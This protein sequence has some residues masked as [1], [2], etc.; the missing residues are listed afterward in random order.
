[1]KIGITMLAV[2]ASHTAAAILGA[3]DISSRQNTET[4]LLAITDFKLNGTGCPEKSS[5]SV[6]YLDQ[7]TLTIIFDKFKLITIPAKS[8][9]TKIGCDIDLTLRAAPLWHH[10]TIDSIERGDATIGN[11]TTAKF[12]TG[13]AWTFDGDNSELEWVCALNYLV[14][15]LVSYEHQN[16]SKVFTY[17]VI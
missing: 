4:P 5:G 11:T 16:F 13:A 12:S 14:L 15:T 17:I 10:G 9:S 8:G 6:K 2:V 1:M 3:A 7:Q